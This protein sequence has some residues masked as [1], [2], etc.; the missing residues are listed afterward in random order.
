MGDCS[1]LILGRAEASRGRASPGIRDHSLEEELVAQAVGTIYV[2]CQ[3]EMAGLCEIFGSVSS[4]RGN[5][6]TAHRIEADC[7]R[8]CTSVSVADA[9]VS[10]KKL[11]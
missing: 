10:N 6:F 2:L 3:E 11:S 5:K 4:S 9:G 1:K 7:V 8:S